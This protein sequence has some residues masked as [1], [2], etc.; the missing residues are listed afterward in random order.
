MEYR[1]FLDCLHD[2]WRLVVGGRL[3]DASLL[4]E[5]RRSVPAADLAENSERFLGRLQKIGLARRLADSV[6]VVGLMEGTNAS[7]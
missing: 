6:A 4:A 7:N 1:D 3:E 5:A 2:R